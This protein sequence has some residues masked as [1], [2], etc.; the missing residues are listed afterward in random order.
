MASST[1]PSRCSTAAGS[2]ALRFKVDLPN[3]GVFDEKRVFAPG[4]M[5]GPVNFR[6]VRIGIPICED[7]WGDRSLPNASPK[8]AAKSCWCPTARRIAA[9][10]SISGSS[11]AVARVKET[12]LPLIYVNQIGGQDELVFDGAS[13]VL[14]GDALACAADA[15]LRGGIVTT[16]W[17]RD[18]DGWRCA[19][20]R[21]HALDRGREADYARLHAG[22]ARLCRQERLSGRGAR[23]FR[24]HRFR[25]LVAAHRRSMRSAPSACAP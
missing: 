24:R 6:G 2:P 1:T 20:A 7:I 8:P 22:P 25:D 14:N 10:R 16:H 21:S 18:A 9:A 23:S 4:P 3:Y 12:G 17:T 11:V 13:F 15:G 19:Q 5:P